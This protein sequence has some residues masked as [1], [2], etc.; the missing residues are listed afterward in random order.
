MSSVEMRGIAKRYGTVQALDDVDLTLEKGVIHALLGENG[1]GKSTLMKILYG[2][3]KPDSGTISINGN[4]IDMR[5]SLDA[6]RLGI[7]MVHQHFMLVPILSVTENIVAN[8]E[9]RKGIR[10]DYSSALT[11]VESLAKSVNFSLNPKARVSELSVGQ[12]QRV[13]ILKVLYRGADILIFDEPTAMLTPLEVDE[14]FVTLRNLKAQGKSV[15]IIT[16]KLHEVMDVADKITVL[17]DG[18][19]IGNIDKKDTTR[20][21]LA[22]MMV[23]RQV[24]I[25]KRRR[26]QSFGQAFCEIRNLN[27]EIAGTSVLKNINLTV[28]RGEILGIAGIEGNGQSELLEVITGISIPDTMDMTLDGKKLTG[29]VKDFIWQGVGHIPEDRNAQGLAT[30][31]SVAENLIMGYEEKTPFSKKGFMHWRDVFRY[32][33]DCIKKYGIKTAGERALAS[34]LSGGNQQKI[35]VARVFAQNPDFVVCAQPTRGV[36]IAAA[37]YIHNVIFDFRDQGKAVLLV[38]ADLDEVKKLSDTVAVMCKGEI[39]AL[40]Q[41]DN[42][43]DV[44]LGLLMTGAQREEVQVAL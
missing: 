34:S 6:I 2:M 21:A 7:G 18:R 20:E 36:D 26:T 35:V 32:G 39:V 5:D 17:R 15:V 19:L 27:Y 40:D 23:G 43:D 22:A 4:T 33:V 42:Y 9:P 28:R 31:L 29:S 38:S 8:D 41:T 13:E 16:H 25:D 10:F 24:A 44:R 11:Q 1:A 30:G 37:D 3:E 12:R 14:F